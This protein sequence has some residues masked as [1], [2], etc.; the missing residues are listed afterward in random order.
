M[1]THPPEAGIDYRAI[2][3]GLPG[4]FVILD[5]GLRIVGVSDAYNQA[6]MTRREDM[7]GKT[8]FEVFPDNPGDPRADG[9]RNLYTSLR[10]VL[11]S[12]QPDTM[13]VQ[14]YDV[15]R[16]GPDGGFEERYWSPVNTP[17]LD[18]DGRVRYIV[19]KATDVT[20]FMRHQRQG[21]ASPG[22]PRCA[23]PPGRAVGGGGVRAVP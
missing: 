17:V 22:T 11:Q 7:L 12:C 10:R 18:A 3:D 13:A 2:V 19:H 9:V 20:A 23:G 14:R 21:P 5:A 1:D 8:M 4:L 6:T 15:R 16:P